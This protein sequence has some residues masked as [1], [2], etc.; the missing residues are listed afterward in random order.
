MGIGTKLSDDT[1]L[2]DGMVKL[3]V[4]PCIPAHGHLKD[5]CRNLEKCKMCGEGFHGICDRK[6]KCVNCGKEHIASDK[7]WEVYRRNNM[8]KR[9][10]TENRFD[11]KGSRERHR[12]KKIVR[13][14]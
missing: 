7:R 2:Y 11:F 4:R 5:V 1:R 12:K 10:M 6:M 3:R 9:T 13:R 14:K 8:I